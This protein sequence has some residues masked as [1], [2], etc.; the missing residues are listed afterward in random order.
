MSDP[1]YGT[2]TDAELKQ[3][4]A[5][6]T[7][8]KDPDQLIAFYRRLHPNRAPTDLLVDIITSQFATIGSIQLAERKCAQGKAPVYL[9]MVTWETPVLGGKMRSPHG[10]DLPLVFAN[11]D[12]AVGLLGDGPEARQMS[13]LMSKTFI[14]FARTGNPNHAGLP[15]WPAYSPERRATFHFDIPPTVVNDPNKEERLFW[16]G[17]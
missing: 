13:T 17:A 2:M 16:T 12:I 6:M 5:F 8:G 1:K 7:S 3:R 9:Y 11:T 14:A 10:V 4:V 15:T